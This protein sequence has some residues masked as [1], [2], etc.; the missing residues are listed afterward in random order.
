M[1]RMSM[2][3]YPLIMILQTDGGVEKEE[4][5]DPKIISK[6]TDRLTNLTQS[7]SHCV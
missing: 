2:L 3:F 5:M 4:K 1:I 7:H 6:F